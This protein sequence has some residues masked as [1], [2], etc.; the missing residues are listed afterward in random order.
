MSIDTDGHTTVIVEST[1]PGVDNERKLLIDKIVSDP[2][3]AFWTTPSGSG[4][5]MKVILIGGLIALGI[6]LIV[7]GR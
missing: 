6:I 4:L 1:L 5:D 7:R 3:T 2:P